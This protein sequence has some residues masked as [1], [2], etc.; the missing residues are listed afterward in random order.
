MRA[1]LTAGLG[2]SLKWGAIVGAAV[3]L[4]GIALGMFN[5]SL[6][7]AGTSDATQRPVL[8]IPICLG[9]FVLLFACSAAGFYAGRETGQAGMGAVA[10]IVVYLVSNLLTI[11]YLPGR[12][13]GGSL[14]GAR[15]A[16]SIIY[17]TVGLLLDLGLAACMGWLG[18]RPGARRSAVAAKPRDTL[19]NI[20][21]PGDPYAATPVPPPESS[22]D[23]H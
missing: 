13:F 6:L 7:A 3:Y 4:A 14:A 17:G 21:L 20:S 5:Q 12:G 8:L 23:Y 16:T 1:G 22:T 10:G 9:F 18:G 15:D 19:E 2:P 11:A